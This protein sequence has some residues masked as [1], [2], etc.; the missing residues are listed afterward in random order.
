M[1]PVV[2]PVEEMLA[3]YGVERKVMKCLYNCYRIRQTVKALGPYTCPW[4]ELNLIRDI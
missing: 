4:S 1:H 2:K 3:E